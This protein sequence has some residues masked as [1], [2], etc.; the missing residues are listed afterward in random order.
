MATNRNAVPAPLRIDSDAAGY[1]EIL[2]SR[3]G[4][5]APA[6][7][8]LL[9][10]EDL[11]RLRK[12]A[13]F[14]SARTPGDAILRAHDAAG[15]MRDEGITVISGFHS[16]IEEECLRILLRGKQ[17]IIVCPARAI[18]AMRIPKEAR[19]AFEAGRVLF[20][21][22]FCRHPKRVTRESAVRR[23]EVVAALADDVYIAHVSPGGDT[24]RL[25]QMLT[26]WRVP[27][28]GESYRR[29]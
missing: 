20:L 6:A 8:V 9:G 25:A 1:P 10:N 17:P 5:E 16:P 22:P 12:T 7:L 11:L 15:R 29:T 19:D 4:A 24:A 23:N 13:L 2:R 14:C 28:V 18:E 27:G 26:A 3:L 21:S